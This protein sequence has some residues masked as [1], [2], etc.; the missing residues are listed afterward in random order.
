M[1]RDTK[2]KTRLD[3]SISKLM[4]ENLKGMHL[5]YKRTYGSNISFALYVEH[6]L[7]AYLGTKEGKQ[8]L[9]QVHTKRR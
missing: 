7:T 3:I 4:S 9:Y 5:E 6:V 2:N 1:P 8:M